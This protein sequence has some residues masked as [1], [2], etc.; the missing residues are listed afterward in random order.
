MGRTITL[1][2]VEFGVSNFKCKF[3]CNNR[4]QEIAYKLWVELITRK[5]AIPL[6]ENDVIV[7]VY[8]SWYSAFSAI[9]ELLKEV[10]GSCLEDASNLITLTI[11]VLNEGLRPHLTT[12]QA[13]YRCWYNEEIKKECNR[14]KT[15]QEI[16]KSFPEYEELI[17]D[18]L[19]T[20]GNIVKFATELKN[21]AFSKNK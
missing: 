6:D 20:N 1:D 8:N 3:K 17:G 18:M 5:I 19:K 21:I 10:P 11:M 14:G 7:E 9:R 13:K 12:W 15:P 2:G 16:Q 4:I